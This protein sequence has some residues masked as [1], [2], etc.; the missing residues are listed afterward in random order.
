MSNTH[1]WTVAAI[2]L[3]AA[4]LRL[5]WPGLSEFKLDEAH[6]YALALE[7]AEFKALPLHGIGSSVG[8][9]NTPLSVY[10]FALPLLLWKS[11]LAAT[12]FVGAL[13]TGAVAL[14]HVMA[15]RYWGDR[16]ALLAT[17]LYAC[18]PWAVIYSRKIWAQDVLP[19]FVVGYGFTALLVFVEARPRW[20]VAHVALLAVIAQIHFSGLALIPVTG[21]L[22]VIFRQR[23][24]WRWVA[25]G[26]AG[27]ALTACP[28]ALYGL[29]QSAALSRLADSPLATLFTRPAVWSTESLELAALVSTGA[30]THSLAGPQAFRTFLALVPSMDWAYGLFG[31]SM[32][33]GLGLSLAAGLKHYATAEATGILLLWLCVPVLLFVRHSTPVYPHY[34]IVLFPVPYLFAALAIDRLIARWAGGWV[35]PLGWATYQTGTLLALFNFI[36]TT[37]TPGGFGTPLSFLLQTAQIARQAS[38]ADILILSPGVYPAVDETPAIFDVL[39]RDR[40]HRFADA[41]DTA[42]FPA[43]D[44]VVIVWPGAAPGAELYAAHAPAV[45][46]VP[47]RAGE[48]VVQIFNSPQTPGAPAPREASAL[49]S[50]G[51]EVLGSGGSAAAWQLWWRAPA[52]NPEDHYQVFAHLLDANGDRLAQADQAAFPVA[53]WRAGDVV[54]SYFALPATG[55]TVRAGFYAYPTLTPVTILDAQGHPSS[56]WLMFN[57]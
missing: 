33:L 3:L 19:V 47:L 17:L 27:A 57:R 22:M 28:F 36:A 23:V 38:V 40:P 51:V 48:G 18:A 11:P 6:L 39:L 14:T 45:A 42:V 53:A 21:A 1:R 44:A 13:N 2:V 34:F 30:Q 43:D 55:P 52:G 4:A 12:L 5:A 50:N 26:A 24:Q 20:L 25:W 54:V 10:L 37:H 31:L 49:L 41:R 29:R 8:L 32:L 46:T 15:R 35:L 16:V 56:E 9:P 7:V